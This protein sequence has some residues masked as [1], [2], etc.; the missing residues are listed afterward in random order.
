[1]VYLPFIIINGTIISIMS[2]ETLA[3]V[4]DTGSSSIKAGF[5]GSDVP[6]TR[7]PTIV[8]VDNEDDVVVGQSAFERQGN[9][10]LFRPI[11]HGI[12]RNWALA[13]SVWEHVFANEL[14]VSQEDH[15]VLLTEPPLN[16]KLHRERCCQLFFESFHTPALYL[17]PTSLLSL[18]SSAKTSGFV[19]DIGE[20]VAH[21]VPIHEGCIMPYTIVRLDIGG[22]DLTSH[23]ISQIE[24]LKQSGFEGR[25]IANLIKEECCYVSKDFDKEIKEMEKNP[26]LFKK[27][28]TLPDGTKINLVKERITSP[29]LLFKPEIAG[30]NCP[31]LAE[32]CYHSVRMCSPELHRTMFSN[33]LLTGGTTLFEGF[34]DRCEY[35]IGALV[36]KNVPVKVISSTHPRD[37]AVWI[38]GSIIANL[39]NFQPMWVTKEEY[40]EAGPTVIHRKCF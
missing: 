28:Y 8:G 14:K 19:L 38:G 36:N 4:I 26:N 34:L 27:E 2:D 40:D 22:F 11:Q 6:K 13:E 15:P 39:P 21:S 37:I 25:R 7:I 12:V 10:G 29:E 3:I 23:L 9:V 31:N 33:I 32:I 16:P 35:E 18:Y 1:M 20:G 17:A 24:V 30:R 5:A